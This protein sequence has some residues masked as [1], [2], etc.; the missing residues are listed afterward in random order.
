MQG[1][2]FSVGLLF[3]KKVNPNNI[4]GNKKQENPNAVTPHLLHV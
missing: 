2:K 4:K 3:I 1:L